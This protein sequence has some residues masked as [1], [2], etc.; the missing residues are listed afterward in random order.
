[1][2]KIFEFK[3]H[4]KIHFELLITRGTHFKTFM[5]SIKFKFK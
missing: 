1:M 2:H 4:L 5:Y 3:L